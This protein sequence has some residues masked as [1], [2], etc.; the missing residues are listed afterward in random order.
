MMFF[1]MK[2]GAKFLGEIDPDNQNI[3]FD[4]HL[5]VFHENL[6][7]NRISLLRKDLFDFIIELP[8]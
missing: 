3:V 4:R 5:Y 1:P 6:P 7:L 8:E 2:R